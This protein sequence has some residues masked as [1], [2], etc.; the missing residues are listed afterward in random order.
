MINEEN[1]N[2]FFLMNEETTESE[3]QISDLSNILNELN[4]TL[5]TDEINKIYKQNYD[6][7][8]LTIP[9]IVNYN[10]NFTLK[11]LLLI[12]DYYGMTKF[13]KSNKFNKEMIIIFLV[14]FENN[15]E[16]E[17]I[18]C[19]RK[20]MWFYI[21]EIKNDKYMKKYVMW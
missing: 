2:I 21:N 20:N 3:S 12:C 10:S 1:D 8:D 17:E 9:Q 18:V 5:L 11:E 16:N 19:K 13:V 6:Q 14:D 15:P 4:D 7:F